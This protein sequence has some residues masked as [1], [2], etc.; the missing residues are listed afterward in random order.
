VFVDF[1]NYSGDPM[2]SQT[3]WVNVWDN[4]VYIKWKKSDGTYTDEWEW[5]NAW[6]PIQPPLAFSGFQIYDKT[7]GFHGRYQV[8]AMA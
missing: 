6:Q 1:A 3:I 7:P 4:P 8:I 5:D 2:K